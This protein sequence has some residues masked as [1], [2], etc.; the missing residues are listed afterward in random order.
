MQSL[1][2]IAWAAISSGRVGKAANVQI[3]LNDCAKKW[4]F[5]CK[6]N[7]QWF[8]F[9]QRQ[10]HG[11]D[12]LLVLYPRAEISTASLTVDRRFL[13]GSATIRARS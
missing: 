6:L 2:H 8:A 13:T 5:I 9:L 4:I 3:A 12:K 1:Q 10:A 7:L 11:I